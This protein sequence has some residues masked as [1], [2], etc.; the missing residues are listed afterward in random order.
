[1]VRANNS[2]H[3]LEQ[4]YEVLFLLNTAD[5]WGGARTE[6]GWTLETRSDL[7]DLC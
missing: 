6:E 1:M 5:R 3:S 7:S 4:S 2:A